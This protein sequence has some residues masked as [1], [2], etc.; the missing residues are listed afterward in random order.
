M[1][2]FN[3]YRISFYAMLFFATLSLNVDDTESKFGFLFPIG[4]ALSGVLAFL[5][6]DRNPKLGLSRSVVNALALVSIGLVFVEYSLDPTQLLQSLSHFLIYLVLIKVFLTKTNEDDW[7]IFGLGL[8]QVAIAAVIN[9]S[10]MVGIVL[11]CWAFLSLWVLALYSLRRDA[12]RYGDQDVSGPTPMAGAEPYPGLLDL[13]FILSAFRVLALTLALGGI[14][15]MAMPRRGI[16][17][18][19]Q[20]G[21]EPMAKHLT[22]FD[23]EVQLGQLGEILENDSIV[24]SVEMFNADKTPHRPGGEPLWR[25][26][27]MVNYDKGRWHA[28]ERHTTT[29]SRLSDGNSDLSRTV[30]Q[31]IK[32][33]ANDSAVLF[34]LR[35][36]VSIGSPQRADP[37]IN[38][39]DG[40]IVRPET[41][42][43]TYDYH[44]LSDL[45][46]SQPQR[47]EAVPSADRLEKLVAL[48][49]ELKI[50]LRAIAEPI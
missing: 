26:V 12:L 27:T 43:G 21:P 24:M 48:P 45:D 33:E 41:R 13:P 30:L 2:F 22:G 20:R 28:Q 47:G 9:Q 4:V 29:L 17:G 18:R 40:T 10:D 8:T 31:Q 25:G 38:S 11:F 5:T 6:V 16:A 39:V 35:P 34:G 44:V 37:E 15:F 32:L 36:I 7:F 19:V 14:I 50:R 42:P 1:I 3:L 23:E 46:Q 49:E